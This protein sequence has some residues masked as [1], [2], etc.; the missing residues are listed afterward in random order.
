MFHEGQ[1]LHYF[2]V[3]LDAL[4]C[5]Q[6]GL[7]L[8]RR[9]E[10]DVTSVL[11]FAC[12]YGRVAR[13]L[14]AAF[15]LA[16][17][18]VADVDQRALS[19]CAEQFHAE[20]LPASREIRAAQLD[21]QYDLIR[22]GSLLTHLEASK[23]PSVLSLFRDHLSS[24]GMVVFTTHGRYVATRL[25]QPIHPYN[26][27]AEQIR[28]LLE[29]YTRDDFGYSEYTKGANYGISVATPYHQFCFANTLQGAQDRRRQR[30]CTSPA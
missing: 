26:L 25:Q 23:W 19:F 16:H 15:P 20:P 10:S 12:G 6:A 30:G 8:A 1:E 14:R 28:P 18:S 29:A 5:I 22:C 9:S 4:R 3:G 24:R 13:M 21:R 27:A 11:D 17:L 2:R 7:E